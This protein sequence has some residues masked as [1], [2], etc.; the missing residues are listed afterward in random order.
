VTDRVAIIGAGIGGL[1]SAALLAARGYHVTVLEKEDWV[2]GKA[3]EVEVDGVPVAG[4]PTV[5]TMRDVFEEVF[6]ECGGSLEDAVD[7]Q[8]ADVIARHAWDDTG[9]L[10][11][12]AD[13]A[14][15]EEA[16]GDFAGE[17]E[18]AA[19]RSFRAEA[20]RIYNVLD[21]PFLRGDSASTPF[22]M[23]WR[24]GIWRIGDQLAMRPFDNLWKAIGGHFKDPRLQQL[25]GRYS[26]YCGSD[27]FRSPATLMLIAHSE[28]KGVWLINGGIH[29]LAKALAELARKNGATIRTGVRV[30]QILTQ[31]GRV[32]G[33][34]L[35]NGETVRADIV[36][37]NADPS[38][39]ARGKFGEAP[40]KSVARMPDAK[41]SLSAM[42]WF[43]HAKT[44]GFDLQHHN[45]FFSP[46]YPREFREIASGSPPNDPTVYLC[47]QDRG[48]SLYSAAAHP[49]GQRERIQMIVNA[50]SN[51][52][53]H[54]YSPEEIERCNHAMRRT[55]R[56]CGLE[57]EDPMPHHLATPQEWER[58]F[59]ATGGALYGR[60]SHGWAA[61]FLRQGPRTKIPGL[62]C[63]GGATH[64]AAGVPMAALSGQLAAKVI[65]ADRASMPKSRP[66]ATPGGISTPSAKTGSTA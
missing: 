62:Y 58:L 6:D 2:G 1:T 41:R 32:G 49:A 57:L 48:G 45:V 65:A 25:F 17:S 11:L 9:T 16:I 59:P 39:L 27:P 60:A 13:P 7:I 14:R 31:S 50:P 40:A 29:A 28:A 30:A 47:A 24:M 42:V 19:Y 34:R 64:P 8:T 20:K 18:A 12:F 10:D 55:L 15:S 63:A 51:G 38:A 44:E 36:I 56:R 35:T 4:G 66:A 5:F 33:V 21:E 23:M 3:R 22:P 52:D 53:T 61:S 37:S 43:A 46:D 54:T 26:T